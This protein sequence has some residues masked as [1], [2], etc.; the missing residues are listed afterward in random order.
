M[1]SLCVVGVRHKEKYNWWRCHQA[2]WKG[3]W[4]WKGRN[5]SLFS[6]ALI[7]TMRNGTRKRL[8]DRTG[9]ENSSSSSSEKG[10]SWVTLDLKLFHLL[11]I[12]LAF[13]VKCHFHDAI[14][15]SGVTC[16]ASH[17]THF[18]V[19][20]SSATHL[21]ASLSAWRR[22]KSIY[23]KYIF[24]SNKIWMDSVSRRMRNMKIISSY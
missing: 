23:V 12:A 4:Y 7:G 19:K 22:W 9:M 11:R 10:N 21:S 2:E 13:V 5:F 24:I 6:S 3:C 1:S 15:S 16:R 17:F 8:A 18:Q 20:V 14:P